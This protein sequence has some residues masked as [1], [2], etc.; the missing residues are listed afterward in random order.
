MGW[1]FLS[2]TMLYLLLTILFS[3]SLVLSFKLFERWGIDGFTAIVFNYW[4]ALAT[5]IFFF[6]GGNALVFHQV[7]QAKWFWPAAGLG[8]LFILVF[9]LTGETTKRRGVGVASVAMKLGLVFPVLWAFLWYGEPFSIWKM[10][11][12]VMAFCSVLLTSGVLEKVNKAEKQSKWAIL[13]PIFVFAGSGMC[14]SVAQFAQKKLLRPTDTGLFAAVDFL[15]AALS[16]TLVWLYFVVKG[17][18][19]HFPSVLAG[20]ALGVPNFL[21]FYYLLTA[22]ENLSHMG[23]AVVFMWVNVSVVLMGIITGILFFKEKLTQK[24]WLGLG[25]ALLAIVLVGL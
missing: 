14:D 3:T 19:V 16:G 24:Q 9:T 25:I 5:G 4:S 11:G 10:T 6:P 21:S 7:A 23:S 1:L 12:V 20:F 22:L 13:L 8:V 17:K 18:K 2:V 15:F